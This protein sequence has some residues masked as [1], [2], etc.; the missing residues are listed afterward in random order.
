MGTAIMELKT[1][2][3]VLDFFHRQGN[4]SKADTLRRTIEFNWIQ[5]IQK[6]TPRGLNILGSEYG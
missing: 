2:K 6:H 5:R 3:S 1:W 4:S